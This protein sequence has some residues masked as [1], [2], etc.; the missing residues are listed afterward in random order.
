MNGLD[1]LR[2]GGDGF[3][4]IEALSDLEWMTDA[5]LE[6]IANRAN[7]IIESR[8]PAPPAP[9]P[10]NREVIERRE[11]GGI[12]YQLEKVRCGKEGCGKCPHG[13][14]WYSYQRQGGKV[15]SKYVGKGIPAFL[16]NSIPPEQLDLLHKK[17]DSLKTPQ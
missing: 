1:K 10:T 12:A 9:A 4:F 14:Y 16:C 17:A 6:M 13:P 5:Q 15:K 8:K 2:N 7:A 3:R 11:V